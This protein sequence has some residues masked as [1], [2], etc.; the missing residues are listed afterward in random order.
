ML[1]EK[2]GDPFAPAFTAVNGRPSSSS[3]H[4][5]TGLPSMTTWGSVPLEVSSRPASHSISPTMTHG[6]KSPDGP[7]KRKRS[8]S[9]EDEL[10]LRGS[11]KDWPTPAKVSPT[12]PYPDQRPSLEPHQRTLPPL[13]RPHPERR[14]TAEPNGY[15][16][17]HQH[18]PRVLEPPHTMPPSQMSDPHDYDDGA[19]ELSR[20]DQQSESKKPG[21]KRQFANRTKT[22]CGTCRRRKKK[23]DEAKPKC[24]NCLR[25]NFECAGYANKIPWS[26]DGASKA[27]PTLQA[28]ER[29]SSAEIPAHY[30]RCGVCNVVHI[31]HCEPT[32]K[33]YP[34]SSVS[35]GSDS[36]RGRPVSVDEQERKPS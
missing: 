34:E 15:Q 16:E 19:T 30:A 35:N 20:D 32:Q 10:R 5:S 28:K 13:D 33:Q 9:I 1:K 36:V 29:V 21:R 12:L 11:S 4:T 14:W 25:G 26:K 3:P 7:S 6:D 17:H 23:C 2:L 8:H 24:N 31:P 27:P 18:D 22:G